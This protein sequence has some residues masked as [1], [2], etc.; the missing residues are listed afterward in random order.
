MV[1]RDF[2]SIPLVNTRSFNKSVKGVIMGGR[3]VVGFTEY[4]GES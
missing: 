3:C 1:M 2:S 4:I